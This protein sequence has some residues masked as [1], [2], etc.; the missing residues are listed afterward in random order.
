MWQATHKYGETKNFLSALESSFWYENMENIIKNAFS[1]YYIVKKHKQNV[2][3]TCQFGD[4]G[5]CV[6]SSLSQ[7]LIDPYYRTIAGFQ[8][9]VHKEWNY[10]K[11]NFIQS[12]AL[13]HDYPGMADPLYTPIFVFFLDCV[14]QLMNQNP[15]LFEFTSE[16]LVFLGYHVYSNKYFEFA[17]EM[18]RDPPVSKEQTPCLLTQ[19][20][21]N[22]FIS[23]FSH[24][25]D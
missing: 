19:M 5:S 20:K 7:L 10:F 13:L 8:V 6:L 14:N 24:L 23:V 11:H 25:K 1:I 15:T 12:S 9:L 21:D 17:S 22:L 2:L 4:A 3:V 16:Y 18:K